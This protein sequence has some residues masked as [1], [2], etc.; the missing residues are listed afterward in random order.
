MG[1]RRQST[2]G[3]ASGLWMPNEQVINR[4]LKLWPFGED[5]DFS[6]VSLLLPMN[7]SNN[8]T[9]FTDESSNIHSITTTGNAKISTAQSQ[10]GGSSAYFDGSGDWISVPTAASPTGAEDCTVEMWIYP[11]AVFDQ[12]RVIFETRAS[13]STGFV[14]FINSSGRLQVFDSAS[15]LQTQSS[16]SV[17]ANSWQ[18]IAL[19]KSG[20]TS[21]YRIGDNSAGTYTL[22]AF[23]TATSCR[24]GSR[25]DGAASYEGYIDMLRITKG[26]ARTIT[27]A[28]TAAFPY[29]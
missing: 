12:D 5:P 16:A 27:A 14:F 20:S 28:P 21:T 15:G 17:S 24:I 4:R 8:S 25:N 1:V 7:G 3:A 22:S 10:Y 23:A 18:Y 2:S 19:V 11:A 26:V 9:T 13:S 29:P 6:N